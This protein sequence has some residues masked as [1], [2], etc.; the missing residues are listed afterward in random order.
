MVAVIAAV[1]D[2]QVAWLL[3]ASAVVLAAALT[4]ATVVA[5][6]RR[7]R[8]DAEQIVMLLEEM[9]SGRVR[10]RVELDARSPFAPIAESA[11]RL[12]QDLGVRL[13]RA[14]SATEGFYALQEAA[15]GYAVIA[16][17]ADGDL[18][19]LSP[20]ATQLFGWEEDAV[21]GRNASL[22]FDENA[23]KDLLPKL[24]RK[25]LR[26]RGVEA[27]SLMLRQDGRRFQAKLL[28]R[29]LRGH[30]DESAGFL[31]VIQDIS[32]QVRVESDLRDAESRSR[33]ILDELPFGVALVEGGRIVVAN[34]AMRTLLGPSDAAVVGRALRECVAT[35]HVILVQDALQRLEAG[36]GPPRVEASVTLADA[37]GNG[38]R[39]VRFVAMA[40][41]NQ[42]RPSVLVVFR[43]QT[44]ERRLVRTL[45]AEETRLDAV[46]DSWDDAVLVVEDDA[47]GSRV[48][49]ANRAFVARFGFMRGQLAGVSEGELLRAMRERG[50]EGEAA[51]ACLAAAATAPA[52][53]T[54]TTADRASSF[55]ASP[56]TTA[57]GGFRLRILAVRDVT[58]EQ[59]TRRAHEDEQ[60]AWRRRDEAAAAA[61]ATLKAMH[62][63][64]IAR[65]DEAERL[66]A[67]LRTLDGMKSDLLANVS[68]ELQTPL[69]SIRG[70]TEMIL[71]GRLGAINEEQKKGLALSLKNIDR[72]IAMIDNLLAFARADRES[73]A[74][75][76]ETVPLLP[77]VD[78]ALSLLGQRIDAKGVK[79]SRAFEDP[80]LA[81][82][83]DRDK[84][85]QVFLNL[86]GNAV[87]FNRDGGAIEISARRGK[88]GF[89]VIQ[90]RDTGVGIA[91]ADLEKVFDRFY[92]A[93]GAAA[94]EEGWGIG[95]AIVRNILRLHGCVIHASSEPGEGTVFSF[96]LPLAEERGAV[97]DV[98]PAV[99]AGP[100]PRRDERPA[101]AT[102]PPADE[103]G[104][105]ETN[106]RPRLKIIR[107]G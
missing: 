82:R 91:K 44:A 87:K 3:A 57:G 98:S 80:A 85:L 35:S 58:G 103:R 105:S 81:A 54:V 30:G 1:A 67:E 60:A 52:N 38:A 73:T 39:E 50:A 83:V 71:K 70:Y 14:E 97:A 29:L 88:P 76:L 6:A 47:A 89:A 25:S 9:R 101:P 46:L 99:E 48:R 26:E 75:T 96:T 36:T 11:N 12:G 66:N 34:P 62:D 72:L 13:T 56:V 102:R 10:R 21:V 27:R 65:R 42:G 18:R 53:E 100:E 59:A 15:R 40:H 37:T 17:D 7:R 94:G 86:L 84:M 69:V 61:H 16:T 55:R 2:L 19:S 92:R 51:A 77:L 93:D 20:G 8:R 95:L 107:R 4:A 23:W 31:I 78:E 24:A 45:A 22:L 32:E 49:L 74:L 43:D 64:L 79:V 33:G 90:V 106:P 41:T 68:H 63:E 104:T 5:L 28:I